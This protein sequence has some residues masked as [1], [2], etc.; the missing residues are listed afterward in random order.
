MENRTSARLLGPGSGITR[1][2][3]ERCGPASGRWQF[4]GFTMDLLSR[5]LSDATGKEV[6]LW[7]SE[8]ALLATFLGAPGRALTRVQLLNAVS[9]RRA[10]AFDR[11]VDVLVG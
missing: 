7:R 6:P 5:T 10:E 3:A 8:F 2:S 11:S 4:E 1:D 9:G